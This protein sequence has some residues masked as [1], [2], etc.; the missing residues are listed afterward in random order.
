MKT[1]KPRRV[2]TD[3]QAREVLQMREEGKKFR[4][5]AEAFGVSIGC[6]QG[7]IYGYTYQE[8]EVR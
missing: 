5:I 8:I 1:R 3:E 4:E 2:L 7:I 6:I